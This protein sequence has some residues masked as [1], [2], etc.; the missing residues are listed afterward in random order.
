MSASRRHYTPD[1]RARTS[2]VGRVASMAQASGCSRQDRLQV[3]DKPAAITVVVGVD[4]WKGSFR[5]V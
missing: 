4:D 3:I 2:L 5:G 1:G